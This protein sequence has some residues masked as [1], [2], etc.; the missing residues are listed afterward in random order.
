MIKAALW[1]SFHVF[2]GKGG[3]PTE[4]EIVQAQQ[5]K[6]NNIRATYHLDQSTVGD[7]VSP[8]CGHTHPWI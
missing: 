7:S 8:V 3:M 2:S 4:A 6:L 5:Y 1:F